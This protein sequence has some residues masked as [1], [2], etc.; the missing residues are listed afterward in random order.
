MMWPTQCVHCRFINTAVVHL[1]E[2]DFPLKQDNGDGFLPVPI[3]V[4]FNLA[5]ASQ[6][7][8][9]ALKIPVAWPQWNQR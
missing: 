3:L 4:S 8:A 9:D 7:P 2:T 6:L 5:I 1:I